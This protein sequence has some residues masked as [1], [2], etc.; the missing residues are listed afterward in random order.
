MKGD[1]KDKHHLH[2]IFACKTI[3]GNKHNARKILEDSRKYAKG[4]QV[5]FYFDRITGFTFFLPLQTL[6]LIL[7]FSHAKGKLHDKTRH[8][9]VNPGL[10]L[11]W[12]DFQETFEA[13]CFNRV[14]Q[15][16]VLVA[17]INDH[18]VCGFDFMAGIMKSL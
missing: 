17:G 2:K 10:C 6:Y 14:W 16:E 13:H 18:F 12:Q 5:V 9:R 4:I 11:P 7:C 8:A 15:G 3:P 1:R